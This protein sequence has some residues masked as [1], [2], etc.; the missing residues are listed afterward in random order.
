MKL[1]IVSFD[2]P[3]PPNYGG[4]VDV[5]YKIKALHGA[6]VKITLHCFTYR[7]RQ[8]D[9]ILETFCE[10]VFY[11]KRKIGFFQ[12]FS[13]LPYIVKSRQH[14]NLLKNLCTDDTPILF[15]G[16]HTC[17]FINHPL[18]EHRK[19]LVRM[20][21]IEWEYYEHLAQTEKKIFKKIFFKLEST[22][23]KRFEEKVFFKGDIFF[24]ISLEDKKYFTGEYFI[25]QE[26]LKNILRN[27]F[28]KKEI[29]KRNS[30][31]QIE[32]K[33][34]D[35]KI[36][37]LPPFHAEEKV[38]SKTGRG[39]YILYHGDLSVND[40]VESVM[41]LIENV[42]SKIDVPII[43]AGKNPDKKLINAIKKHKNIKLIPNPSNEELQTLIYDAQINILHTRHTSG[44]K[45][46]LLH[47][48]FVGRFCF[49]NKE[50]VLGTG[51]ENLCQIYNSFDELK[52]M[53]LGT[54]YKDFQ[55]K[56]ILKRKKILETSFSNKNNA[57]VIL[58]QL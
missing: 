42:F 45:L 50:M 57:A 1:H 2:V 12:H 18:L 16:L 55:G 38:I 52:E 25:E 48:L 44:M 43:I 30:E 19:K 6:G 41:E 29:E 7:D 58:K 49:A 33:I 20:H 31:L 27:N 22:K 28:S 13:N 21:N 14:P 46:K 4:A 5:F 56:E 8:K 32:K 23:L 17:A 15:E 40:N 3:Y 9:E 47:A 37:F 39:K 26:I 35:K 24:S 11:Y 36:F 10:K 53:I 54:M 34:Y 51:L